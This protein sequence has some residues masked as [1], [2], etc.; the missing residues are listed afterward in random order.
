MT[1][2]RII[3]LL[4]FVVL[5]VA[6]CAARPMGVYHRVKKD[7]TLWRISKTYNTDIDTIVE[8]NNLPNK[9]T[10]EEG[11]LI[12]IP[13]AV[14]SAVVTPP[15]AAEEKTPAKSVEKKAVTKTTEKKA[16][17]KTVKKKPVPAKKKTTT[18]ATKGVSSKYRFIWP[19]KGKVSSRFG[20]HSDGMR[21]NNGIKIEGKEG[22]RVMASAAG[23]VILSGPLKY[24]G[25]TVI[26]KHSSN[27]RTV[28]SNL[29][30]RMVTE[31]HAVKKGQLIALLG[32]EEKSGRERLY[33][34]IRYK[35]NAKNPL[36]YL[37]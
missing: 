24:Y 25:E 17:P 3:A 29:S 33:F 18:V 26:I 22:A 11:S 2:L 32:R 16:V 20:L 21:R 27:Y 36:K 14:E 23:T 15:S 31:G 7:E 19:L 1:R 34:E 13:G 8:A 4:F 5:F 35:N 28:Y 30:K 9:E 6:S 37:H 12:F 10:V